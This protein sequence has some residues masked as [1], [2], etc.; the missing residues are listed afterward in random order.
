MNQYKSGVGLIQYY[1][2][3]FKFF[4]SI[5]KN[6]MLSNSNEIQYYLW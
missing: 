1:V 6:Q 4:I 2:M 5:R 3:I